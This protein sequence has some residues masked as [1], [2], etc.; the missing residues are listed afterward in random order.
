MSVQ[1]QARIAGGR[2]SLLVVVSVDVS[3]TVEDLVAAEARQCFCN[4][5]NRCLTYCQWS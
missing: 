3:V 4:I 1:G 5:T 2:G